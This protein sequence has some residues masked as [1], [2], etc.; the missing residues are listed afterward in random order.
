MYFSTS[1]T[2]RAARIGTGSRWFIWVEFQLILVRERTSSAICATV[3]SL[4]ATMHR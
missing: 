4:E 1:P 3:L 2:L